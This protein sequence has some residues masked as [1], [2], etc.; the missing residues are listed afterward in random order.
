MSWGQE[1][2]VTAKGGAECG[3]LWRVGGQEGLTE[4]MEW[5]QAEEAGKA[6]G[7]GPGTQSD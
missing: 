7:A 3:G 5:L 2:A 4:F 6:L 1:V